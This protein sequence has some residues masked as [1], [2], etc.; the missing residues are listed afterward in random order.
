[1]KKRY[2]A[3]IIALLCVLSLSM[4]GCFLSSSEQST[5]KYLTGKGEFIQHSEAKGNYVVTLTVNSD[6]SYVVDVSYGSTDP[7]KTHAEGKMTYVGCYEYDFTTESWGITMNN[8]EYYNVIRLEN[9]QLTMNDKTYNLYIVAHAFS[10][11]S[12]DYGVK[13]VM[14]VPEGDDASYLGSIATRSVEMRLASRS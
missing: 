3:A 1:M 5:F 10:K 9:A 13:L 2:L 6:K 14:R 8:T 12:D 11:R 4:C 7:A